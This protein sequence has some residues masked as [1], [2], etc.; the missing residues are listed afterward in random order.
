M[1]LGTRT[2]LKA[3]LA[4]WL[5]KDDV[6]TL[7]DTWIALAET[8][9]NRDLRVSHMVTRADLTVTDEYADLPA[10]FLAPRLI[11]LKGGDRRVL[12]NMTEEDL[13][14]FKA[15]NP[16]GEVYAFAVVGGEFEFAPA[17][18]GTVELSLSYYAKIPALSDDNETNWVLTNYPDAYLRGALMEAGIYY[19]EDPIT[20]ANAPLF[21]GALQDINNSSRGDVEGGALN[22]MPSGYSF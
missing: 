20:N 12:V 14:G 10:D 22:V 8:R 3:A 13:A 2:E 7:A 21:Q 17:P 6:E 5:E 19:G 11:R 9:M 16:T 4:D 18:T 1:A 15:A